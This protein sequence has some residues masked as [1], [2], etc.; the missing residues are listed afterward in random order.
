M[1]AKE[2]QKKTMSDPPTGEG[3][4]RTVIRRLLE[5]TPAERF[6]LA[7]EEARNLAKFEAKLRGR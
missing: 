7:V 5:L 2:R 3:V 4:D 1:A 6:R